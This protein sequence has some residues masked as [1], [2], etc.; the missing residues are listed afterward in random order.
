M[1]DRM[2]KKTTVQQNYDCVKHCKKYGIL[3]K[4]FLM[5][6]LPG[7]T[8]ETIKDTER[9]ILT[10]GIDDAQ[11]AIYYPYKGTQFREEM[12]SGK[13]DDLFFTGEGL[14]AYGAKKNLTEAVVRTKE[15]SSEDLIRIRDEL[16]EKY[17]FYTHTQRHK[18]DDKF[19]DTHLKYSTGGDIGCTT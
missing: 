1:L 14:G 16:I 15:L 18:D 5:I 7:E 10:S 4:A 17:K 9:F 8:L 2:D 12:E 6:G 11:L 13:A 19:F 3:V